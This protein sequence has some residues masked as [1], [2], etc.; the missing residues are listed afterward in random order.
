MLLNCIQNYNTLNHTRGTQAELLQLSKVTFCFLSWSLG[1]LNARRW[2]NC[3]VEGHHGKVPEGDSTYI[4][5][6]K[7][8]VEFH[9]S[10]VQNT[11]QLCCKGFN[12]RVIADVN[13]TSRP[14]QNQ[15][16]V[17]EIAQPWRIGLNLKPTFI[18]RTLGKI[19]FP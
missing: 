11:H 7:G 13:Q 12:V 17:V 16:C 9:L 6:R 2:H 14:A 1:N 8:M 15:F 3:F 10:V 5:E 19:L 18:S 4:S